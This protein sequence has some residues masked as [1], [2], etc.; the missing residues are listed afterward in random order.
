MGLCVSHSEYAAVQAI[1]LRGHVALRHVG[2]M[3]GKERFRRPLGE[4]R[5]RP[6]RRHAHG[7][8]RY[9]LTPYRSCTTNPHLFLAN[10]NRVNHPTRRSTSDTEA[11]ALPERPARPR[12]KRNFQ[13]RSTPGSRKYT[14]SM[15]ARVCG[16]VLRGLWSPCLPRGGVVGPVFNGRV[17]NGVPAVRVA[18]SGYY[19]KL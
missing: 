13:V 18:V 10:Q 9:V 14:G 17:G 16:P 15:C 5:S 8:G 4:P 7:S 1:R 6:P 12:G 11:I 2:G 19:E 3:F